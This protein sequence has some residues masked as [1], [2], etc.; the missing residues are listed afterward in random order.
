MN[1]LWLSPETIKSGLIIYGA[2]IVRKSNL[3]FIGG[4]YK[5]IFAVPKSVLL[6]YFN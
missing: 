3:Y 5:Q 6:S 1:V 2:V 4:A